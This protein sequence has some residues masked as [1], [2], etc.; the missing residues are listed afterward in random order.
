[1]SGR[2][3]LTF[4]NES[5]AYRAAR[6]RLLAQEVELRRRMEEVAAVRRALPP[7]GEVP[8]DY[9]FQGMRPDGTRGDVRLSE[10]FAPGRDS[11]VVYNMILELIGRRRM[12]Q[13]ALKRA[14]PVLRFSEHLSAEH[15]LRRDAERLGREVL[16]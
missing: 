2:A 5:E 7:G 9:I 10:L 14:G 15:G 16:E 11:L 12:L 1:M 4:P 6:D 8:Q 13:K 3:S